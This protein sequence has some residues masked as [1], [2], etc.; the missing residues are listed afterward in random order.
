MTL[1]RWSALGMREGRTQGAVVAALRA[2]LRT[3]Y[4]AA[5]CSPAAEV[6]FL[7]SPKR[8]AGVAEWQTRMP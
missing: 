8:S 1:R 3:M 2:R 5:R 7:S 4:R 6:S